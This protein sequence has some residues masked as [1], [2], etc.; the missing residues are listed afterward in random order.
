MDISE[1]VMNKIKDSKKIS[2]KQPS[3]AFAMSV[4]AYN[5]AKKNKLRLEEAYA[6]FAM[7]LACRS[8]TKINDCFNY[9]LDAF[10]I[11][12]MYGNPLDLADTLNLIGIVHFYNAMYERA[13]EN[14]LKALHLLEETR[15][16]STM[17]RILNNIGEVYK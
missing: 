4:E 8:M 5:T 1:M 9:A 11:F 10:K 13:L 6:L 17:S 14:F 16:Y 15:N 3:L 7:A 12:E 2:F